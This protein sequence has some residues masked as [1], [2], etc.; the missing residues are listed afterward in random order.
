M[1]KCADKARYKLR[2]WVNERV[3]EIPGCKTNPSHSCDMG[4]IERLWGK[5][6]DQCDFKTLCSANT[7]SLIS[8]SLTAVFFG[9]ATYF[10]L[11]VSS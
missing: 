4:E 9:V 2:A 10:S 5:L 11:S 7:G 8:T 1:Y 6:A 3:V